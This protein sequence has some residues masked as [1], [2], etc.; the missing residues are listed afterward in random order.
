VKIWEDAWEAF[1]PFLS[2][3][4]GRAQAALHHQHHRELELPAAQGHRTARTV[5][6][7]ARSDLD[8]IATL[9]RHTSVLRDQQR[10]RVKVRRNPPLPRSCRIAVRPLTAPYVEAIVYIVVP[11]SEV[12]RSREDDN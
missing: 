12:A 4:P 8:Y 3:H 11:K 2:L 7:D 1:T 6:P 5:D 9:S 10:F